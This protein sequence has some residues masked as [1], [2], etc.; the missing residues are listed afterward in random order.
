V[1]PDDREIV[2]DIISARACF[3]KAKS[4]SL[5]SWSKPAEQ[6][7]LRLRFVFAER[8]VAGYICF[9]RNTTPSASMS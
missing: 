3:D 2:R 5:S 9:G 4:I 7:R 1:Q 6:S 8:E